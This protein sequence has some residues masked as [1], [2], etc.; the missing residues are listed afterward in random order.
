MDIVCK[1]FHDMFVMCRTICFAI[2]LCNCPDLHGSNPGGNIR[3]SDTD[4][5][6]LDRIKGVHDMFVS[7]AHSDIPDMFHDMFVLISPD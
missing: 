4:S 6:T 7:R 1:M 2:C 3:T 5:S